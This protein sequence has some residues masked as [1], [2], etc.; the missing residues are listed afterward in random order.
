MGV[1]AKY[2]NGQMGDYTHAHCKFTVKD[3]HSKYSHSTTATSSSTNSVVYHVNDPHGRRNRDPAL[4]WLRR[5]LQVR[6]GTH[7]R[8]HRLRLLRCL[9]HHHHHRRVEGCWLRRLRRH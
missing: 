3:G 6:P 7:G 1:E 8:E 4:R 9:L 2:S 5:G